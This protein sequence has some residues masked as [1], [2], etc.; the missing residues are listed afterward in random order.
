MELRAMRRDRAARIGPE[1]F[2]AERAFADC[3][4]RIEMTGR[5][6]GQALLIGCPDASWPERLGSIAVEVEVRDPGPLFASE[7]GGELICEDSW[8]PPSDRHDVVLAMGTLDTVN[9]LP[10]ALRLI[11][12]TMS[13]NS[14]FIG[15]MAG[16]HT[17]PQL[18]KAML[19][20][21]ALAG[22]AAPRV[23][24]RIEPSALA[25]LLESAGFAKPVVDVERV[26]V[27]YR[28]LARLV[29]DL[30]AMAAT[31]ILHER[32]GSLS[33]RQS[34]AAAKAFETAGDGERTVE[35]F[36]LLYFAAWTAAKG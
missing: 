27:S 13:E 22:A 16:G 21:D 7:A 24:P 5:R 32:G 6:F 3:L 26:S 14:L 34:A 15:V 19:A 11:R 8:A 20:A 12:R 2:L 29:A 1:L 31:N 4:E 18:R 28:R 33:R 35:T 17:L 9:D 23:H 10:V 30:R 36:E 25:P